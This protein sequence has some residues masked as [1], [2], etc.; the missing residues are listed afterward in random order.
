MKTFGVVR[1]ENKISTRK[2]MP[3]I[4]RHRKISTARHF[5]NGRH[6]TAKIQHYSI[7]KVAFNYF[8]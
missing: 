2:K 1:E 7:S 4:R 8:F 3:N 6:N 5:Q